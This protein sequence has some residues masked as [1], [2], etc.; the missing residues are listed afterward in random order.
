MEQPLITALATA[1]G[2]GG[3]AIVR[4]SGAGAWNAVKKIFKPKAQLDWEK[5]SGFSLHYGLIEWEN[6][7]YDEVLLALMK[8]EASYTRE[9]MAEIQCHGG[10]IAA[11][12]IIELLLNLGAQ[13]AAPGEFT[14]RAFLNGRLDLSQAEAVIETIEARGEKDLEFSLRRLEGEKGKNYLLIRNDLLNL[15]AQTEAVID[16]PEDG[17]DEEVS[18]NIE[19]QVRSMLVKL[20]KEIKKAEEGSIYREGI[21]TVILGRTNVGKSSLMNALLQE[22]RAIVTD[23]PGT[24]RDTIEEKV[25]LAGVPLSIIDTAGIRETQ[26][27]VEKIGV[28][29][30]RD[31]L[32]NC[33]LVLVVL[34]SAQGFTPEDKEL[35][36]AVEDKK[37]IVLLNKCDIAT[38]D[39]NLEKALGSL[40]YLYIS[41]KEGNNLENLGKLIEKMFLTGAI[42]ESDDKWVGNLRHKESF[43]AAR[44]HL[45]E[46]LHG[47]AAKVPLDFQVIDLRSALDALGEISGESIST[48]IINR[49]FSDFCIGK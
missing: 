40:P 35:L 3:I 30:S 45:N 32:K 13:L 23:I 14:K 44:Y 17:L 36:T 16:F 33:D 24:T 11:R 41:A 12:R 48:E 10:F 18:K 21:K 20:D 42:N 19:T 43:I 15:V 6:K 26:D 9:E 37:A 27:P 7:I 25:I 47:I 46:V 28:N 1:Q 29:R 8:K 4:L 34:D 31:A 5:V 38:E 22:E 2:V 49:I 39:E